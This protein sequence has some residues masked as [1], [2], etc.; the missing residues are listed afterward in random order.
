[1]QLCVLALYLT[2]NAGCAMNN[3]QS[4]NETAMTTHHVSSEQG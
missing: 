2:F 1:L 4:R 3:K